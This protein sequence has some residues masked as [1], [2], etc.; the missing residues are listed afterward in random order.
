MCACPHHPAP[1]LFASCKTETLSPLDTH[2]PA[3]RPPVRSVSVTSSPPGTCMSGVV[4]CLSC[5]RLI[6]LS[7]VSSRAVHV[8]AGV[9]IAFVL[10]LKNVP[11]WTG[12]ISL[13]PSSVDGCAGRFCV[14]RVGHAAV[15]MRVQMPCGGPASLLWGSCPGAGLPSRV[16]LALCLML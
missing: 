14:S 6:S 2:S 8:V 9:G 3:P 5:E 11:V 15:N 10:R 7:T 1:G 12:H 4:R 13:I 16:F